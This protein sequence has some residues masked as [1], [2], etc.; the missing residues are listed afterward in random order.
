MSPVHFAILFPGRTG[1]SY[2]VSSLDSHPA[3]I[4]RGEELVHVAAPRQAKWLARFYDE[5]QDAA[6]RAVGFKTKLKDVWDDDAFADFLRR[7]QVRIVTLVRRNVL[8][9]AVSTLNAQRIAAATGKW[10]RMRGAAEL[11]PLDVEP[12]QL[13][14]VVATCEKRQVR[15]ER[16]VAGLDLPTLRIEYETLLADRDRCFAQAFEFLEVPAAPLDSNVLKATNDDLQHALANFDAIA[17]H[18]AGGPWETFLSQD[19]G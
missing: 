8:K 17:A 10:N 4:A 3:I 19:A 12:G 18:F 5:P 2:F 9:L 15:L 7:R 1:S 6:I 16:F 13:A 11:S 14:D